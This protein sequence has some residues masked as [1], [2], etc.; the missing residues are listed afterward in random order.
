MK[1]VLIIGAGFGGLATAL[2]LSSLGYEVEIVE[3]N[4]KPGGRMNLIE[5]DG[6][7]FDLGPSFM[8]MTYEL[9]ELFS[10]ANEKIPVNLIELDPLYQVFFEGNDR[11]FRI[12][13]DI[14]KLKR[15]FEGI[16]K[17]LDI[18]LEKFLSKAGEFFRDTENRVV[19]KNFDNKLQY[20][21][22]LAKVPKKHLPY[23]FKNVWQEVSK[24]FDSNEAR[25]IFSLVAF[26]LGGSPFNTP[27]IYTLLNYT[28]MKHN[29]YWAIEGGM[30]KLVEETTKILERRNVKF[31][32]NSEIAEVI[33][34]NNKILYVQDLTGKKYYADIF[35]SNHDAADFRGRYLRRSKFSEENLKK[36]EWT[37]APFTMYL[38]YKGKIDK[39]IL[40]NYFLGTNFKGYSDKIFTTS[41][42]PQKP[43]YYVNVLSKLD[44]TTAPPDCENI[45]ILMP[46]PTLIYKPDYSDKEI[47]AKNLIEDL[48]KRLDINL[49]QN[50]VFKKVLAPDDWAKKLNLYKGSG[51]GLAHGIFQVGAFR[52]RNKDEVIKN[53][54]YVGASTT[55]GTGIPMVIISS[56]LTTERIIKDE[57]SL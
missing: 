32:F 28:E 49:E 13:K 19:K 35:I 2:R 6:F 14:N 7:R 3:K 22:E 53:L 8:S 27:A 56:K 17:N 57:K 16:E 43:Y 50:L 47:I 39:L 4:D 29:G 34:A 42:L 55:P 48:S 41:I 37:L 15:E 52:P 26:F 11:S 40:H 18:K 10:Y 44:K 21:L 45:F 9:E 51:L 23:L 46:A 1:K 24:H 5:A 38:G 31:S 54:Y 25:I 30:Y 20:L 36:M 33:V 12:Y